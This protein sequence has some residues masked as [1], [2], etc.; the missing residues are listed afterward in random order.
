[1]VGAG[2]VV[3]CSGGEEEV[4]QQIETP[5]PSASASPALASPTLTPSTAPTPQAASPSLAD[6]PAPTAAWKTLSNST[7]RYSI[8]LP[9][10]WLVDPFDG[11][12]E[13]ASYYVDVYNYN[14]RTKLHDDRQDVKLEIV[15]RENSRGLTLEEWIADYNQR[16]RDTAGCPLNVLS[17]QESAAA[18]ITGLRIEFTFL[19]GHSD[20]STRVMWLFRSP[21]GIHIISGAAAESPHLGVVSTV[22]ANLTIEC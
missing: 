7:Y 8:K 5:A 3:A 17:S 2:T 15:F 4:V 13:T 9:A 12:D 20:G 19:C 18:N 22:V 14:P 21:L 16:S 6:T 11:G 1:M 10:D